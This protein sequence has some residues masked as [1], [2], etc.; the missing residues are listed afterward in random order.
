MLD[1]RGHGKRSISSS[2][3][4]S[5][6]IITIDSHRMAQAVHCQVVN[7]R[8]IQYIQGIIQLSLLAGASCRATFAPIMHHPSIYHTFVCASARCMIPNRHDTPCPFRGRRRD[9]RL[10]T[11]KWPR[12]GKFTYHIGH[13]SSMIRVK[14]ATATILIFETCL[15]RLY[16]PRHVPSYAG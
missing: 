12:L 5:L 6:E 9:R 14:A 13:N 11:P 7:L 3:A 16:V 8:P 4:L 1:W 2:Q 15:S 10:C